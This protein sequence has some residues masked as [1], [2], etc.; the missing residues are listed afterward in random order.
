VVE[1]IFLDCGR[2]TA[3]LMRDSL[4]GPA[5]TPAD[6]PIEAARLYATLMEELKLRVSLVLDITHQRVTVPGADAA[7]IE[8]TCIQLRK[9]LELIAFGSLVANRTKYAVAYANFAEHWNAKRMLQNLAKIHKDFYPRPL[10]IGAQEQSGV[11]SFVDV[12]RPFL[13]QDDFI[14][15]YDA[16]SKALHIRNPFQSAAPIDFRISIADWIVRIQQLLGIHLVR[17]VDT[18]DLW[19]VNL[20]T[21]GDGKVH[22]SLASP[23]KG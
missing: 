4:G 7:P 8:L 10:A 14:F 22:V 23:H 12:D 2:P 16:A 1:Q 18:P 3:Q 15:L 17:F 21:P 9:I 5:S 11:H 19:V 6:S 13:T 20:N